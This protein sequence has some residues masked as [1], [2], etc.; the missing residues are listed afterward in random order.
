[1]DLLFCPLLRVESWMCAEEGEPSL[2]FSSSVG[3]RRDDGGGM[4]S[5]SPG[6]VGTGA[7]GLLGD[8]LALTAVIVLQI[9]WEYLI[10]L[11]SIMYTHSSIL[12]SAS[13]IWGKFTLSNH[14]AI[15]ATRS[16]CCC[17]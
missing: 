4:K 12:Y 14:S 15:F 6:T 9:A 10:K 16:G 1:M 3:W 5:G 7:C 11:S 2:I 8:L 13:L 17:R